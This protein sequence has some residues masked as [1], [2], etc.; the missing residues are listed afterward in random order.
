MSHAVHVL[1]L[2]I[3]MRGKTLCTYYIC[4][5]LFLMLNKT[6]LLPGAKF[7]TQIHYITP[8]Y[9]ILSSGQDSLRQWRRVGWP[10]LGWSTGRPWTT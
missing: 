2:M 1:Q 3:R 4:T 10:F 9:V 8:H 5:Q 6:D 7:I